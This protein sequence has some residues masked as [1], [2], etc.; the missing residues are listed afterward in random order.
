MSRTSTALALISA[1]ALGACAERPAPV[2][3]SAMV[4]LGNSLASLNESDTYL[5]QFRG[6]DIP[7]DFEAAVA[8][9][10]GTVV[11]A[12]A[13]V[14][15]AAVSGMT[16]AGAQGLLVSDGVASVDADAYTI[17]E[18]PSET[19]V[20]AA[21]VVEST[22][23]PAAAFFFPRQWHHTQ[24]GAPAAWAAGKLGSASTKVGIIDTGIDYTNLDLVGLIDETLSTSFVV[25]PVPPNL[26]IAGA[27]SYADYHFHGTHVG[28][29]VSSNAV[30]GAGVTSKVKLVALK[31]CR[32]TGTC[33]TSGTL[34]AILYAA[35]NGL[36]VVNMSL[37]GGFFRNGANVGAGPSFIATINRVFNYAFQKGTT[38]VVSAGNDAMD[39]D[40]NGNIYNTYCNA[41]HVICVSATGP[42][43]RGPLVNGAYTFLTNIDALA[44]YSNFGRSAIAVAAPGGAAAPVWQ[45][46]SRFAATTG[47][48]VCRTGNFILGANG[49]SMAAPHV[50]GL[51][52]L[53]AG[54]VGNNPTAI[55]ARIKATAVDLGQ[56]GTDPAYGRGRISVAAGAP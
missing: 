1:F 29:T 26:V 17:L 40:H 10:G 23:N 51:A 3:P 7:G 20:E 15:I 48:T 36:P 41:P 5:V 11:F 30:V 21:D 16:D 53:I 27:R 18:E 19:I 39:I 9:A 47:L 44:S 22:A 45:T 25:D 54:E 42:T 31:V 14:G 43:A 49:T 34:S 28:S 13:G 24:I 8:A 37:G 38:I 12:H 2:E 46:C 50:T 32:W 35:D 6:N 55:A 56:P 52:A 4:S 33:P